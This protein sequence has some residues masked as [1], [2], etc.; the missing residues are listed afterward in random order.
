MCMCSIILLLCERICE[1]SKTT[2]C[3]LECVRPRSFSRFATLLIAINSGVVCGAFRAGF[4]P[5]RMGVQLGC[6][7]SS[8]NSLPGLQAVSAPSRASP[9][10]SI[11][12]RSRLRLI[13]KTVICRKTQRVNKEHA[14]MK[15]DQC[16][17]VG[18]HRISV[19]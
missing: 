3:V 8:P 4:D 2:D 15:K 16:C 18:R 6:V 9:P 5:S 11:M 7:A 19:N 10:P 17:F 1:S 12:L 14:G 13:T